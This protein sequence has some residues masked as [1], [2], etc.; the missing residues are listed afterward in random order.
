MKRSFGFGCRFDL[1]FVLLCV[2]H[3]IFLSLGFFFSSRRR[4]TRCALVTGVQ[5]VLFRSKKRCAPYHCV[6]Q[7]FAPPFQSGV[8]SMT[9]RFSRS[10][11]ASHGVSSRTLAA[12][13]YCSISA[14]HSL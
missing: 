9:Q 2:L 8:P 1:R 10:S 14:W 11:R 13:A 4:H 7:A 12:S 6:F 5:R 3:R